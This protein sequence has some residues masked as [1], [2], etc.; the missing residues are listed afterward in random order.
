MLS[1][2]LMIGSC[3]PEALYNRHSGDVNAIFA[4]LGENPEKAHRH[5]PAN[6]TEFATKYSQGFYT[7]TSADAK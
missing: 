3:L 6:A 4:E 5:P 1:H 2:I 7:F